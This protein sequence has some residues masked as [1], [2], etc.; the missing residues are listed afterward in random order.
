MPT[1]KQAV[2][3]INH[4]KTENGE[5]YEG[6]VFASAALNDLVQHGTLL[7]THADPGEAE[8]LN[9]L[10]QAGQEVEDHL[11]KQI[12]IAEI[13]IKGLRAQ[14]AE[15]DSFIHD[16]EAN[17][18]PAG[19]VRENTLYRDQLKQVNAM[20]KRLKGE[21]AERDA[22]LRHIYNLEPLAGE[23]S[24]RIEATLSASAEPSP[25]L[26]VQRYDIQGGDSFGVYPTEDT[27]GEW[28][29]WEDLRAALGLK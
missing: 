28:V 8:R 21:L 15:R 12:D 24:R 13:T 22:L 23:T 20:I 9:L 17:A 25:L 27:G 7:Y 26:G 18:D 3:K 6:V 19:T 2:A 10:V 11:S 1:N 5:R 16:L 29:R 4:I 14:L